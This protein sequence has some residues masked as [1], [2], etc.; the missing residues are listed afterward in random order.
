M[1][2]PLRLIALE[3]TRRCVLACRHCRAS[4]GRQAVRNE[5]TGQEWRRLIDNV[6]GFARPTVILT[7]GEPLLR[8][9]VYDIAAHATGRNLRVVLATCGAVLDDASAKRLVDS[10][11]AAISVSLDGAAAESHDAFR[12]QEGA[13]EAAMRGIDSA[14]RAGLVFQVNTTVTR[15]NVQELPATLEL[16]AALGAGTFNPFLLV[17]TGRGQGLAEEALSAEQ[18]EQTLTWLADRRGCGG[19]EIRVTCAPHYQRVLR[20]RGIVPDRSAK[21]CMGGQSFAFVS[22][23]GKVQACGFLEIECGDVRKADY[24]LAEIW[25]TSPVFLSLRDPRRYRGRCGVCEFHAVCGGCR[26]RALAATGDYLDEEPMC[27]HQP[28][29]HVPATK[30]K[31]S[32]LN[33][34]D[35]ELLWAAQVRFPVAVRPFELLGRRLGM[36]SQDVLD[37]LR[38]FRKNGFIRRLGAVFDSRRLGYVSTLVAAAVPPDRLEQAAAMVAAMPGVTHCYS[39]RHRLNLWFTLTAPSQAQIDAALDD[40]QRQGG[41]SK[42]DIHSLPAERV[43]KIQAVFVPPGLAVSDEEFFSDATL[44]QPGPPVSLDTAQRELVKLLAGDL[45]LAEQP[46]DSAACGVGWTAE[47]LTDQVKSWLVEGVIRR[48]GAVVSHRRLGYV[49][50]GMAVFRVPPDR[51]DEAGAAFAHLP[52]VSHCYRRRPVAGFDYNLYAMIHG[53]SVEEVRRLADQLAAQAAAT[54]HDVLLTDRE[55]VKTSPIYF[56]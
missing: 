6:A 43:Y 23:R 31:A 27:L 55:F 11:V 45:P 54:D 28:S 56:S 9:D 52:L 18:Y 44:A 35:K 12:G 50:N 40:L 10:G 39:R 49:T 16:A 41:I 25:K 26:G 22:H 33:E 3:L 46:F 24:D 17:P 34:K 47:Q 30:T 36:E 15:G 13:F 37:R 14:K 32:A 53:R 2:P 8:D 7:G 21:G 4:A 51:I 20:Q 29:R 19:M 38:R 48:F 5:L 1:V 42:K